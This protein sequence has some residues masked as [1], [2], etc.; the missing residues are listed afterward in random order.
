MPEVRIKTDFG[1]VVIPYNNLSELEL[2]LQDI[3]KVTELVA[4][5]AGNVV[6]A[7][8][9][10]AFEDIFGFASGGL[11]ELYKTPDTELKTVVLVLFAYHP[12]GATTEDI[13]KSSG[14]K[15]AARNYLT[16]GGSKK[17]FSKLSKGRY[18]LSQEGLVFATT[19]IIP[20]LRSP[21]K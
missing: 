6:K 18:G 13:F 17:Y 2:G 1:E 4:K 21:T 10:T 15:D 8:T 20:E 5:K 16:A 12:A 11:V 14:V 19:R 9:K 7:R 3:D